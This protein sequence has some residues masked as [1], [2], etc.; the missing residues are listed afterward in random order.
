MHRHQ[1]YI[2]MSG[3]RVS[4]ESASRFDRYVHVQRIFEVVHR[5]EVD[6][7]SV[8]Y[9]QLV[10]V[11]ISELQAGTHAQI[12]GFNT[13]FPN[14]KVSAG[15]A[16]P[17]WPWKCTHTHENLKA[18]SQSPN[19]PGFK[20]RLSQGWKAACFV[21][22]MGH[23]AASNYNERIHVVLIAS[24]QAGHTVPLL[25]LA[26]AL[27][28]SGVIVSIVCTDLHLEELKAAKAVSPTHDPNIRLVALQDGTALSSAT[29]LDMVRDQP[30]LEARLAECLDLVL[31]KM[32]MSG[33][34]GQQQQSTDDDD[35]LNFGATP[36]CCL[37]SSMF[38]IG[39]THDVATKHHLESHL[40]ITSN[41]TLLCF[42]LQVMILLQLELHCSLFY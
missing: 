39:W 40:L 7:F 34:H 26:R 27:A 17:F 33:E 41:A 10:A 29:F 15:S 35:T 11:I 9:I 14:L 36:P 28:S 3:T 38:V 31:G 37:I 32:L 4:R 18:E 16:L 1:Y 20:W 21:T 13:P 42:A 23:E 22:N 25:Q 8:A 5:R 24:P 19:L 6:E 12:T 30:S 2:D